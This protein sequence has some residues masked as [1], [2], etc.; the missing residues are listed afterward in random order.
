MLNSTANSLVLSVHLNSGL[1]VRPG[2]WGEGQDKQKVPPGFEVFS[3]VYNF[4]FSALH[5]LVGYDTLHL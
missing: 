4:E 2:L 1:G 5:V 3:G